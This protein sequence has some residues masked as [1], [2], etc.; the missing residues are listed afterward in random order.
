LSLGAFAA[1]ELVRIEDSLYVV[2]YVFRYLTFVIGFPMMKWAKP[3][4]GLMV[5]N[6][7]SLIKA[8]KLQLY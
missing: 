6:V 5:F 3:S 7:G 2:A 1:L 4:H 8:W